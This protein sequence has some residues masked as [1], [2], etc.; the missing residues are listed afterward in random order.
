[1]IIINNNINYNYF[2]I[3][4]Y[5]CKHI[6]LYFQVN[7]KNTGILVVFLSPIDLSQCII[8]CLEIGSLYDI[9]ELL[10]HS[11]ETTINR[12]KYLSHLNTKLLIEC[13]FTT[14]EFP[15]IPQ[16]KPLI[17]IESDMKN[18]HHDTVCLN[19]RTWQQL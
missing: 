6:L 13:I 9:T 3:D 18:H 2:S 16:V 5:I 11:C 19:F 10:L 14:T 1:M 8:Y 17:E 4:Y 7:K 15:C 12:Y